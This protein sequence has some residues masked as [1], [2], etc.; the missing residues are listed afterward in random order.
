MLSSIAK[1]ETHIANLLLADDCLRTIET[2]KAMGIKIKIKKINSTSLDVLVVGNGLRGLIKPKKALYL[3]NSGTTMRLISG[4]LAGQAFSARLRGDNSLSNRPMKRVTHPL[5]LMGAKITGRADAN[6]APLEI[7]GRPILHAIN[8]NSEVPSAQVK[9]CLLLAGLY[10]DGPTSIT[11]PI[12]SRDHT[13]RML[14]KFH[15]RL[16]TKGL[17]LTVYPPRQLYPAGKIKIPGDFSSAAFFIGGACIL[18]GSHIIIKDVGINPTRIGFIHILKKMGADIQF[19]NRRY[20]GLEPIADLVINNRELN[21]VTVE[22]SLIPSAIDELPILMVVATQ[23]EGVTVI[24][25]TSEL[26]VKE[27]DRINSM[28]TGLSSMRAD[29]EVVG[30]NLKIFGKTPLKAASVNSFKDHRTAMC[31]AIAA[32][33]AKGKTLIEDTDCINTS[34]PTFKKILDSICVYK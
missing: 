20:F 18:K 17:R 3:G 28:I 22:E 6:F 12:K 2:F 14:K 11:E 13:E 10:S 21:A 23:A 29:I 5:R 1:G 33:C 4:I 31:M 24:K 7:E 32:L 8:Y 9:S 26:R 16:T 30:N 34:F 25:G 27:T 15:V 19:K